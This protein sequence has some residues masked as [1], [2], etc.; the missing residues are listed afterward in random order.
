MTGN[1][2]RVNVDVK[3][4]DKYAP[5]IRNIK[6]VTLDKRRKIRSIRGDICI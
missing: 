1:S 2:I 5:K 3:N 4:I 6:D